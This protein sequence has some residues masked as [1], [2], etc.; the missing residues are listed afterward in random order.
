[1]GPAMDG[2]LAGAELG[3]LLNPHVSQYVLRNN[4]TSCMYYMEHV[5][6]RA[7]WNLFRNRSLPGKLSPFEIRDDLDV[8]HRILYELSGAGKALKRGLEI[9]RSTDVSN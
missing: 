4:K 7:S 9:A 8:H 3:G 5:Y 2:V 6:S 1:M